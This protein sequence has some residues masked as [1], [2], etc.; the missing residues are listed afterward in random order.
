MPNGA[1][2]LAL[3]NVMLPDVPT[4]P[5][6][7]WLDA[8]TRRILEH[9]ETFHLPNTE[10]LLDS[11]LALSPVVATG[12]LFVGLVYLLWGWRA[13]KILVGL[14]AA[15]L[16]A[17]AGLLVVV[18]LGLPA[19]WW[20]AMLC[21]GVLAGVLAWPLMKFFV[22]LTAGVVGAAYGYAIFEQV[23]LSAG[24]SGWA[25]YAWIGGLAGSILA[26]G[27]AFGIFRLCVM[28]VTAMQGAGMFLAGVLGLL[29]KLPSVG[30]PL[31]E[32][33]SQFPPTFVLGVLAVGA[34]GFAVQGIAVRREK[35]R[36]AAQAA[37]QDDDK[38]TERTPA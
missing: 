37:D 36:H 31:R 18:E 33:L 17:I 23:V 5:M 30:E 12:L 16:G 22:A 11:L 34:A 1:D 10:E 7:D 14:H 29:L 28:I 27:L 26:A 32:K 19:Y 15:A 38:N 4:K 25:P 2:N 13:F 6:P 21:G 3:P 35:K 24:K 8:L 9:P 20:I